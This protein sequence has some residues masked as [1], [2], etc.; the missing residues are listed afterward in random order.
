MH[1]EL[2]LA[3]DQ[4]RNM[5]NDRIWFIPVLLNDAQIPAHDISDREKLSD[6][7]AVPLFPDWNLGLTK[8]LVAMRMDVTVPPVYTASRENTKQLQLGGQQRE[9]TVMFSDI[10]SFTTLVEGFSADELCRFLNEYLSPIT[11]VILQEK[12]TIDKYL[13]DAIMAFWNA[14]E[15]DPA[16]GIHG[17]RSALKMRE[18]LVRMNAGWME[19]AEKVG[20]SFR[21]VKFG[22][23]LNTGECAVGYMG[24]VQVPAYSA[25]GEEAN[26][27]S[28]LEGACKIFEVDIIC[29]ETTRAKALEFAWLEINSVL[30]KNKVKPVGLYALIGGVDLAKSDEFAKLSRVHSAML[31][32]YRNRDF[33]RALT[34]ASEGA[35]LAPDA[36]RGLYGYN[37]R[38]FAQ[39]AE[40][41]SDPDWRPLI[42]LDEK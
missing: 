29:S 34:L 2:R 25:I 6:I 5:P 19:R 10:R 21:P 14:P 18:A 7:Q 16:H 32:A 36:V 15:D 24:S 11:D 38:R 27:A 9:L 23:G 4:L 40:S 22:I 35:A 20:R 28:R 3:I 33:A 8:I 13:G 42:A 1:G 30:L 41:S 37:G 17:V 26:I 39:L 12:G 31:G